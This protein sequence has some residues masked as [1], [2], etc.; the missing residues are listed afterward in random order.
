MALTPFPIPNIAPAQ[1]IRGN[2]VL[3]GSGDRLARLGARPLVVG[4]DRTLNVAMPF[5][6][7]PLAALAVDTASY[8]KD[9]SE[10]S[11]ASLHQA[12]DGHQ[13]DFIIG[14]GGGKFGG[15]GRG[16]LQQFAHH[17]RRR[18]TKLVLVP[19]GCQD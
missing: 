12:A 7:E 2:G 5:L 17:P 13:A 3:A 9:C 1:V 8:Q 19:A 14:V 4:G 11:L 15:A 10:T 6:A 18:G 16:V